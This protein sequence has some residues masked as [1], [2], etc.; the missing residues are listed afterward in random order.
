MARCD[1]EV[2]P[3]RTSAEADEST[4]G[5]CPLSPTLVRGLKADSSGQSETDTARHPG[6]DSI[7]LA[8]APVPRAFLAS[9]A[10]GDRDESRPAVKSDHHHRLGGPDPNRRIAYHCASAKE[11]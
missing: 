3:K 8:E 11:P 1:D 2:P 6:I 9:P 7:G 5:G 4:H 10:L